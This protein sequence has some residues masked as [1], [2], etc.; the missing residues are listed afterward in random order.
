MSIVRTALVTMVAVALAAAARA[1]ALKLGDKAPKTDVKMKNVDGKDVSI[2]DVTGAKGTLVIFTCNHCPF[3]KAWETR[4]AEVGNAYAKKGVGVIAINPNDP[5]EHAEDSF[6]QMQARA[7]ERSFQF[8][9]VVDATSD[10]ARAFGA[11][12]TPEFFLFDANGKLVYHGAL[13][14]NKDSKS[15]DKHYLSDA[16]NAL[17][18]GQPIPVAETKAVGCTIK[19]RAKA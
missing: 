6:E 18:A 10:V 15:V 14:D 11:S 19:F 4:I 5:S 13:D 16:L 8:A 1:E 17:L 3:V 9:Y 7:K 12:R 2:A